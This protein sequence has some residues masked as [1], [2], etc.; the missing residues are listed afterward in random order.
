MSQCGVSEVNECG[1]VCLC[2]PTLTM[3]PTAM[4]F[5]CTVVRQYLKEIFLRVSFLWN[6]PHFVVTFHGPLSLPLDLSFEYKFGYSVSM[7]QN[8]FLLSMQSLPVIL[9]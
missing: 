5:A 9:I 1:E 8:C 2:V 3:S 7:N 4:M 6:L